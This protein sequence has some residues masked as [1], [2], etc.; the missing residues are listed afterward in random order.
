LLASA[1]RL[2]GWLENRS[3][4]GAWQTLV[5]APAARRIFGANIMLCALLLALPVPIPFSN[6]FPAFPIALTAAAY[7]QNDGKMLA[8]AAAAAVINLLFW[9]V[10][11]TL[12]IL[13]G[14]TVVQK[15]RDLLPF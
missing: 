8:R 11:G 5:T 14:W 4:E 7:L 3:R 12:I 10:W 15:A 6:V 2:L 9:G 13:F 1:G